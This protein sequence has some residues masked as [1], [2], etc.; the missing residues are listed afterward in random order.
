MPIRKNKN[1]SKGFSLIEVMIAAGVLIT[2]IIGASTFQKS[3]FQKTVTNNDRA[4]AAQKATQMFEELRAFVQA[5][6]EDALKNLQ[7]YYGNG[8]NQFIPT[9]TIEK[10]PNLSTPN[11]RRKDLPVD[12]ADPLSGNTIRSRNPDARW[13]FT[14]QVLVDPVPTDPYARYVTVK[15]WYAN[16]ENEPL[17]RRNTLAT[18]SGILKTNVNKSPP[19]Q[20]YDVYILALENVPGWW[21]DVASLR[22]IFDRTLDDLSSRNT[23]LELRKH[24]INR[25]SYGR[26]PYYMPYIN[27]A[28]DTTGSIPWVYFYPGKITPTKNDNGVRANYVETNITG[29]IRND[30]NSKFF[31]IRKPND[32]VVPGSAYTASSTAYRQYALADQYNHGMRYEDERAAYQRAQALAPVGTTVEPSLRLLLEDMNTS[33]DRYRNAMVINLHGELLPLPPI[34]NYSD[35]A[36]RPESNPEVR[37]VTHPE[38]LHY[39]NNESLKLRVYGYKTVPHGQ[40]QL[41]NYVEAMRDNENLRTVSLWIPTDGDGTSSGYLRHPD[42]TPSSGGINVEKIIGNDRVPY[43]RRTS[44]ASVTAPAALTGTY[45]EPITGIDDW[46]TGA[47]PVD[48]QRIGDNTTGALLSK[49]GAANNE[50]CFSNSLIQNTTARDTI[51]NR[52]RDQLIVINA[53][54]PTGINRVVRRVLEVDN[55]TSCGGSNSRDRITVYGGAIASEDYV[56][57]RFVTRHR[58]YDLDILSKSIHG[59]NTPGILIRL[60]DTHLRTPQES[61]GTSKAGLKSDKRLFRQEYV[62][63]PISNDFS[64]DLRE[65]S[66]TAKADAVKNTARWVVTL[67]PNTITGLQGE[68]VTVE[69][70][71]GGA[72]ANLYTPNLEQGIAGDGNVYRPD[73]INRMREELYNVSRTY[74]YMGRTVPATERSQFVG[75]PRHMP[76][77]DVKLAHRYNPQ[78]Q[79]SITAAGYSNFDKN[80]GP[81]FGHGRSDVD[82]IR[83]GN[84]FTEGIMRSNAIYN[85]ISGWSNY[86]FGLG[87]DIGADGENVQF[88]INAQSFRENSDTGSLSVEDA[89]VADIFQGIGNRIV[90]S[91][92]QGEDATRWYG[93]YWLGELYPDNEAAFWRANGNLPNASYNSASHGSPYVS[94]GEGS[95][96]PTN[97]YWRSAFNATPLN[98]DSNRSRRTGQSGCVA[99]VNG[100]NAGTG[101]AKIFRH[102][103]DGSGTGT[104]TSVA[105][106]RLNSAFNLSLVSN[107]TAKR[108]FS[109][110]ADKADAPPNYSDSAVAGMTRNKLQLTNVETGSL[111]G[112]SS[113]DNSFYLHTSNTLQMVSSVVQLSRVGQPWV[114]FMLVNGLSPA[115]DSGAITLARFSQAGML[116]AYLNGGD[117]VGGIGDDENRVRP[118]PRIEITYPQPE[119]VQENKSVI[120]VK[121]S[122]AWQR[123]DKEKYAP[124]YPSTWHDVSRLRFVARYSADNGQTWRHLNGTQSTVPLGMFDAAGAVFADSKSLDDQEDEYTIDWNVSTLERGTY[125]LR[126]EAYRVDANS[127]ELLSL[128]YAYH[129]TYVSIRK[130]N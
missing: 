47:V 30:D 74:V 8:I 66:T 6:N 32:V 46:S 65:K 62:P 129:Y 104:L 108:P 42:F 113:V 38:Q 77:L 78:F 101:D 17:D 112:S 2:V 64:I 97:S 44:T 68:V 14:R 116:Q 76:Y 27:S 79:S 80:N 102:F 21:V 91:K 103:D 48:V 63:A 95:N 69:T 37:V 92:K 49:S 89:G 36:K 94:Q 96:T 85:S 40:T 39:N 126:L 51:R 107:P 105:G 9:L 31:G 114:G 53:G 123:W 13:K 26:D 35:A 90:M 50:L 98:L 43:F 16:D 83:Y 87:G 15:I 118:I 84:L 121:F 41:E 23:G 7:D 3:I 130:T 117:I 127:G 52:L 72:G 82:F 120:P 34:R 29:R 99:F 73:D 75:D 56:T 57:G 12:P 86:Y 100:N 55:D 61:T 58:D 119:E 24:Y 54:S 111:S 1:L 88:S 60:F 71:I 28:Q 11:D 106:T 109:I 5:N 22:P 18:V 124:S 70:R 25:L 115:K 125:I 20:V 110:N 122:V 10:R 59:E 81:A 93:I 67:N 33:P 4:F 19:T 45:L 128:G